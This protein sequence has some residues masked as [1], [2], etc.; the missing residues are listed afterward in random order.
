M[1][2]LK[3]KTDIFVGVFPDLIIY[4]SDANMQWT[5]APQRYVSKI[6]CYSWFPLPKE[7]KCSQMKTISDDCSTV[8]L[9]THK[10]T[11]LI[12]PILK[13]ILISSAAAR[14]PSPLGIFQFPA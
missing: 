1:A 10:W 4:R 6:Q 2:E 7:I 5:V 14:R 3:N 11:S 8:R 13:P 9:L 12:V